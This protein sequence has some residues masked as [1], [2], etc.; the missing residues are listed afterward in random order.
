MKKYADIYL[1]LLV[2]FIVLPMLL[3]IFLAFSQG[4][5]ANL[6][7]ME[8]S[9]NNFTKYL[10]QKAYIK[11]TMTSLFLAFVSTVICLLIGYPCAYYISKQPAKKRNSLLLLFIIPMWMNF[12]LR[13]YAWLSILGKTGVLNRIL[14]AVGIGPL[15]LL[16]NNKAVLLGM[17]YNFLPFMVLPIHSVLL[18]IDNSLLEAARDLG[19]N[20]SEVFWKVVFP[21]SKAGI[22]TGVSM[23]FIPAVS[24]FVIT[25]LL[26][27]NKYMLIGNVIEKQFKYTGDW[28]FG[29]AISVVLMLI[30]MVA[31][32]F[33]NRFDKDAKG[34]RGLW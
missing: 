30:I 3:I 18:K 1:F 9:L 19:A 6:K 16:Y 22:V 27:G 11:I 5:M 32:T 17:V 23:V 24:T 15:N 25:N 4:D 29:S 31:M 8:F 13:T 2:L 14:G 10:G 34:G 7:A 20:E 28:N 26:G 12:L 21:L 33:M